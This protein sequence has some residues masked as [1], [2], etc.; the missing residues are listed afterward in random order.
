MATAT[1]DVFVQWPT[2]P[3]SMTKVNKISN[4]MLAPKQRL[5]SAQNTA[6]IYLYHQSHNCKDKIDR[7][8]ITHPR[9]NILSKSVAENNDE[10]H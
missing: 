8:A 10:E 4:K 9:I 2:A 5:R 6:E 7:E 3:H 1:T